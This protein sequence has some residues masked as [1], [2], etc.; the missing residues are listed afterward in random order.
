MRI[1]QVKYEKVIDAK[2]D[3]IRKHFHYG[4][5]SKKELECNEMKEWITPHLDTVNDLID[6][7]FLLLD[8]EDDRLK[9]ISTQA[10]KASATTA[11][12]EKLTNQTVVAK[13]QSEEDEK[14]IRD[15]IEAMLKIVDD[16]EMNSTDDCLLVQAQ[17]E[18]ID[19]LLDSQNKSWNTLKALTHSKLMNLLPSSN[20]RI[21]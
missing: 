14:L 8:A 10:E 7:V 18:E 19:V 12:R 15:R 4:D 2:E 6:E 3:L 11:E 13:K 1:M 20:Q 16:D 9:G 5:K 17:L 21:R